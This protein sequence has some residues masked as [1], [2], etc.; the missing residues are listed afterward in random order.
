MRGDRRAGV[1]EEK[2]EVCESCE[3]GEEGEVEVEEEE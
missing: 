2:W 1:R 3:L